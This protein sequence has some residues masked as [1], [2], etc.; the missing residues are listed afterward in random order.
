LSL[1]HVL[2]GST[3]IISVI[4]FRRNCFYSNDFHRL[5]GAA[6]APFAWK[7]GVSE[8]HETLERS[9]IPVLMAIER[10]GVRVESTQNLCVAP[11]A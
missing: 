2:S 8:V 5:S 4:L 7:S 3:G 10:A 9:L 11:R 6:P 1:V